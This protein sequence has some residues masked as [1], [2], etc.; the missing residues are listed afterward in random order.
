MK[1]Y[2]STINFGF[3]PLP[4]VL[5]LSAQPPYRAIEISSGHP[6]DSRSWDAPSRYAREHDASVLLHNY[7]P[8]G[9]DNLLINL[10]DPNPAA[11]AQVIAFLKSRIDLTRELGSDYYSF[12]AGYRVPYKIGVRSYDTGQKLGRAEA[13]GIFIE[14]VREVVAHAES[15]GVHIGVE[16]HV[17]EQGNEENLI[18]Y[19]IEDFEVLLDS[20]RSDSVGNKY[21]PKNSRPKFSAT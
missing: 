20:V 10:S 21:V 12:H 3:G 15:A 5:G 8:P 13:L 9:P 17:V 4:E 2:V 16:N 6:W 19:G 7:A 11:R 18:L 1:V 14:A